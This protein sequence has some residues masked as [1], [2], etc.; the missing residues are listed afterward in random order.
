MSENFRTGG[1]PVWRVVL[2]ALIAVTIPV[3]F[4][5][6]RLGELTPP[7]RVLFWFSVV[8]LGP[9]MVVSFAA[10]PWIAKSLKTGPP[11]R[12]QVIRLV[13]AAVLV[14]GFVCE[15]LARIHWK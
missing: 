4:F 8:F 2:Y 10:L 13:F 12:R 5:Y 15:I 11:K 14:F 1:P 3:Y 9:G 7:L 6:S